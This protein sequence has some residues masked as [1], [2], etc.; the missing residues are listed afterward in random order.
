MERVEGLKKDKVLLGQK[1]EAE[2]D[3]KPPAKRTISDLQN[4]QY[5]KFSRKLMVCNIP[6]SWY[7]TYVP[8]SWYNMCLAEH[9]SE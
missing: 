4:E 5:S 2:E 9:K 1:R 3:D 8:C 7:V 6:C